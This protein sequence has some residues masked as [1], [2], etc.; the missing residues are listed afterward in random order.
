MTGRSSHRR[1]R[2]RSPMPE[3]RRDEAREHQTDNQ[4]KNDSG[5]WRVCKEPLEIGQ[6]QQ[7]SRL[8]RTGRRGISRSRLA[9]DHMR[10]QPKSDKNPKDRT[11]KRYTIPYEFWCTLVSFRVR[12]DAVHDTTQHHS[13]FVAYRGFPHQE[14]L[15][16]SCRFLRCSRK[17]PCFRRCLCGTQPA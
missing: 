1:K 7:L 9:A 4:A 2:Q 3:R 12:Q 10:E 11:Q 15:L 14:D 16:R 8:K 17:T 5:V 6:T 13:D